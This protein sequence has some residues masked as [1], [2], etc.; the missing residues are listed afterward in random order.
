MTKSGVK[1]GRMFEGCTIEEWLHFLFDTC[2]WTHAHTQ[3]LLR[4]ATCGAALAL[5]KSRVTS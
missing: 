4:T 5:A 3:P 2:T 1:S